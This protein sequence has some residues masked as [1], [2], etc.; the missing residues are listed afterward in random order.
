MSIYRN[1]VGLKFDFGVIE[2]ES[3]QLASALYDNYDLPMWAAYFNRDCRLAFH[4]F[5]QLDD[6]FVDGDY[7][8]QKDDF[9]KHL[10]N[11]AKSILIDNDEYDSRKPISDVMF[12]KPIS[13][14]DAGSYGVL[15]D[16]IFDERGYPIISEH[17]NMASHKIMLAAKNHNI[18]ELPHFHLSDALDTFCDSNFLNETLSFPTKHHITDEEYVIYI[19]YDKTKDIEIAVKVIYED[20]IP[21][22]SLDEMEMLYRDMERLKITPPISFSTKLTIHNSNCLIIG[23]K[24]MSEFNPH[25]IKNKAQ[26]FNSLKKKV[27]MMHENNILHMDLHPL[28]VVVDEQNEPYIIDFVTSIPITKARSN[29]DLLEY[30]EG[31]VT[32]KHGRDIDEYIKD[33]DNLELILTLGKNFGNNTFVLT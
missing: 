32:Y 18:Y 1:K 33:E 20:N 7:C 3:M 12:Y 31:V 24:F 5:S 11:Y 26:F 2:G 6:Y 23:Q 9:V 19:M 27:R 25:T 16:N 28:N 10:E 13:N 14:L 22:L 15:D 21:F 30:S 29:P 4:V 17:V 8:L